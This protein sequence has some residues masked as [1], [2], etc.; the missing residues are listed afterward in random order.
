YYISSPDGNTWTSPVRIAQVAS[1]CG[2]SMIAYGNTLYYMLQSGNLLWY[3]PTA[4]GSS[5]SVMSPAPQQ[6][7][8]STAPTSLIYNDVVYCFTN[9][10]G[11]VNFNTFSTSGWAI[12]GTA[13]GTM[14]GSPGPVVFNGQLYIFYQRS[15]NSG[16][17]CYTY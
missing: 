16:A 7:T 9:S 15:N 5:T 2:P 13:P 8:A 17:L 12:G 6:I 4:P 14:S 11:A 3:T 1:P 10:N